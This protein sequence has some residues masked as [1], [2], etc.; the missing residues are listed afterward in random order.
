MAKIKKWNVFLKNKDGSFSELMD[1]SYDGK[2]IYFSTFN[3]DAAKSTRVDHLNSMGSLG[4]NSNGQGMIAYVWDGGPVRTSHQEFG[5]RVTVGDKPLALSPGG[6]HATH[7]TGTIAAN[8]TEPSARGMAYQSNT[9]TYMWSRDLVNMTEAAMN[10]GMLLSNHSY[11]GIFKYI[12][13]S[14]IGAYIDRS[15]KL[16]EL[17]YCAPYYLA[18]QAAGNDGDDKRSNEEPLDISINY[19]KLYSFSTAKNNLV[20]ASAFDARIGPKGN[21]IA[22]TINNYSSTGPT[23]DYRIKPDITGNGYNVFSSTSDSDDSYTFNSGTSMAAPNVTGTL[24]LLQQHYFNLHDHF[25]RAA[26]L[27]GLALHTADDIGSFGPDAI[28]G[29]G[30]LNAKKAA[31]AINQNSST[32]RELTLSQGETYIITIN[33]NSLDRLVAS[34]SWTD[35]PGE[36]STGI[37]NDKSPVLVNDLD[38]RITKNKNTYFPYKL[39]SGSTNKR[40]DNIVDPYERID[41]PGPSSS[42]TLEVSHKGSLVSGSQ[43]FSLII[44]GL[45]SVTSNKTTVP[46][47]VTDSAAKQKTAIN[48]DKFSSLMLYPNPSKGIVN[49]K[50]PENILYYTLYNSLGRPVMEKEIATKNFHINLEALPKGFYFL[51]VKNKK[52]EMIRRIIIKE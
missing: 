38:L 27:K 43:N 46:V 18:I 1:V 9:I 15:S 11:G 19:D 42:Y 34:I 45:Q 5:G 25:M 33:S 36:V 47:F 39:T 16:D 51:K 23:D 35:P 52:G 7:V 6:P 40:G 14:E 22:A 29:W 21:L 44:T 20:V 8:G 28:S 10:K 49:I 31:E 2:P 37:A 24:L 32:I 4:L 17:L 12:P 3:R 50:S 48:K 41:V 26:T 30:L 13:D